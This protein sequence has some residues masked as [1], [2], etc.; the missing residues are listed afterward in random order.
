MYIYI[1]AHVFISHRM[2]YNN[3]RLRECDGISARSMAA[4]HD[5]QPARRDVGPPASSVRAIPE[6]LMGRGLALRQTRRRQRL[7]GRPDVALRRARHRRLGESGPHGRGRL[8]GRGRHTPPQPLPALV[9]T[10][11]PLRAPRRVARSARRVRALWRSESDDRL[12]SDTA[13]AGA[14]RP[15]S[16]RVIYVCAQAD[17]CDE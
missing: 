5:R 7:E 2:L 8:V 15:A 6:P 16:V 17:R 4:G 13:T 9:A 1:Y 14:A 3:I 11:L 10:Q 12:R